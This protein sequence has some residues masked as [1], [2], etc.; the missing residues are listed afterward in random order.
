MVQQQP[1]RNASFERAIKVFRRHGGVLRTSEAIR[2]GIHPR[3]LYAMRDAGVLECLSRGLYRIADLPHLSNPDLVAVA[4]KVPTGVI[5]LISALAYHEL[6]TQIPHEVYL[7]LPRGAEP[8]RLDHPPI[9]I[10]WFTGKAFAEG[11]DTHEVDGVPVR[12]YGV[13][14]T[15]ADCFKYRNK[16]GLDTAV[17]ALKGYVSGRRIDIDKLMVYARICRVEKVMRPYLEALL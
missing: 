8:P 13:E 17:E 6:T 4:L 1:D 2:L 11:I 10:F 16:I 15:L 9:R 5:C 7:A 12:I 3:T 14:K